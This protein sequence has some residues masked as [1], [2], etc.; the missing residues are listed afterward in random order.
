MRKHVG[1]RR[2]EIVELHCDKNVFKFRLVLGN[3]ILKVSSMTIQSTRILLLTNNPCLLAKR[4]T[5]FKN[6]KF[7]VSG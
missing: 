3:A 1:P 2:G 7:K 6:E 4:K 5:L